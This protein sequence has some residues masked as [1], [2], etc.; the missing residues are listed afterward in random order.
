M[1]LDCHIMYQYGIAIMGVVFFRGNHN[2][3]DLKGKDND[4]IQKSSFFWINISLGR[5]NIF[6]PIENIGNELQ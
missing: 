5:W 3:A 6:L 2:V 4:K 1:T